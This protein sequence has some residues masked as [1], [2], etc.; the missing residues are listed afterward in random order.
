MQIENGTNSTNPDSDSAGNRELPDDATSSK[1][2]SDIEESD[3]VAKEESGPEDSPPLSP[4][5]ALDSDGGE[6]LLKSDVDPM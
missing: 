2:L 5:G 1:T 3:G 4:D 6:R